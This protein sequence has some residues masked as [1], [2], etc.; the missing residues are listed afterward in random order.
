MPKDRF[1]TRA[2]YDSNFK[3]GVSELSNQ[4]FRTI[5]FKQT[6]FLKKLYGNKYLS[7]WEK[8]FIKDILSKNSLSEKQINIIKNIHRLKNK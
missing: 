6:E 3:Y 4:S 1:H 8:N 7:P 2:S 5:T